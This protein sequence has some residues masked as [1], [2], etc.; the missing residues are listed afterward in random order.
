MKNRATV[1]AAG[2]L[3]LLL[4]GCSWPLHARELQMIQPLQ[5]LGC[6]RDAAGVVLSASDSPVTPGEGSLRLSAR[7]DSLVRAAEALQDSGA[8]EELFFAHVDYVLVGEGSARS[9]VG[10]VLDWF[11]R[12]TQTRLRLPLFL[13]RGGTARELVTDSRDEQY[14]IAALLKALEENARRRGEVV[15]PTLLETA[16]SLAEDG[17]AL[18]CALRAEAGDKE[19]SAETGAVLPRICGYGVL[20]EGALAGWLDLPA[21]RGATV[22]L[23]KAGEISYALPDGAGTATVTLRRCRARLRPLRGPDGELLFRAEISARA[24]LTGLTESGGLTR[25]RLAR[26]EAALEAALKEEA[27]SSLEA[28]RELGADF[29]GLRDAAER[30]FPG[31]AGEKEAFLSSFQWEVVPRAEIVR[32]YD[33]TGAPARE[34]GEDR[35]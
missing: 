1:P 27:E 8:R 13:V 10:E 30:A 4:A 9:G 19:L 24:A 15:C 14:E 2:L 29:L 21:A 28:V 11:E 35:G 32:S 20:Q 22:L 17:T 7:G 34:G 26:L 31:A 18:C 33:V 16:R 23:N 12:S 6:D 3:L 5:T 25:L